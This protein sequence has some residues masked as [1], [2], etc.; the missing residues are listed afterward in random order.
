MP[1][2]KPN[3][4]SKKTEEKKKAKVVEDKTFGLKNKKG[5]KQQKFI[6]QV[7][8]NVKSG[9]DPIQKK[10][11][12]QRKKDKEKK[13]QEAKDKAMVQE[14]FTPIIDKVDKSVDPKSVLCPMFKQSV[15]A[16]GLKCKY[17]H[18]LNIGRKVEKRNLY[19]DSRDVEEG[20]MD[21]GKLKELIDAKEGQGEKTKPK[22]AI[23]CKHFL[24]AVEGNKY[25]WFWK[26]P[27]GDKCI[28][29]HALPEGYVLKK[30]MKKEDKGDEISIEELVEKQRA[31][32]GSNLTKITYVTFLAWKKR[33]LAERK[34][35][36]QK[37]Q[38]KKKKDATSGRSGGL[39]GMDMFRFNPNLGTGDAEL[40]EGD[41]GM[42]LSGLPADEA[43]EGA[44]EVVYKTWTLEGVQQV[45]I[46]EA[47]EV[48]AKEMANGAVEGG[49]VGGADAVP[50]DEN[51]FDADD[52][53]LDDLEEDLEELDISQ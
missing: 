22:T 29:R 53:E 30:D 26:C 4:P 24:E 3:A 12:D 44:A 31:A 23:I 17:S 39:T 9:G 15:C 2:K 45:Q 7:N 43:E 14:L 34:K 19:V 8:K 21:E 48:K 37:K 11:D 41:E 49:A 10:I 32:L 47:E 52:A 40:E 38:A 27:S 20:E 6:Q 33:K 1:P 5:T 42:D 13:E 36:E 25:G 28:Y 46:D 18:D 16:K 50:I 35:T 51:L